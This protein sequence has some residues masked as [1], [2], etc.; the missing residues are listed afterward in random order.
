LE[1]PESRTVSAFP[2][3][4]LALG[5]LLQA[6]PSSAVVAAPIACARE[7][8]PFRFPEPTRQRI[9]VPDSIL[10]QNAGGRTDRE[11]VGL[12]SQEA[13]GANGEGNQPLLSRLD[14]FDEFQC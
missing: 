5:V 10:R 12:H 3:R 14:P 4:P 7:P 11:F 6:F 13:F 2:P 8:V 1:Q 9:H